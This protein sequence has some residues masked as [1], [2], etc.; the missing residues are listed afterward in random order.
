MPL[1]KRYPNRKLY[2]TTAKRYITLEGI[3][4][5]IR[6][7]ED[8]Q[9]VDHK[10]DE[11]LT[12]VTLAQI[13]FEE[14]RQKSGL[15]PRALL[16]GLIRTGGDTLHYLR[17]SF[18]S[19]VG[20]MHLF[21]EEIERRLDALVERGALDRDEAQQLR[22]ELLATLAEPHKDVISGVRDHKL[23]GF[24]QWLSVPTRAYVYRLQ[25]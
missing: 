5:L 10:T 21:R 12:A 2:D 17:R 7:G 14:M 20:A 22:E 4:D 11:D 16:T 6:S 25:N 8:V 18:Y 24:L 1:I 3:A 15:L 19:S 9:V 23:D 13:I